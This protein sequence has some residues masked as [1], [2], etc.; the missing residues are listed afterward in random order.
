MCRKAAPHSPSCTFYYEY[1]K[2]NVRLFLLIA[3]LLTF[4]MFAQPP[5]EK[6]DFLIVEDPSYFLIYN[7]YQQRMTFRESARLLPYQPLQIL[8]EDDFLSDG[9]TPCMKVKSGSEIYFVIKDREGNLVTESEPNYQQVFKN[10]TVLED[11]AEVINGRVIF[12]AK[13]PTYKSTLRSKKYF[14]EKG[15]QLLRLFSKDGFVYVQNL[16]PETDFG[17]SNLTAN[18]QNSWWRIKKR[19]SPLNTSIPPEISR[20]IEEKIREVNYIVE[21]LF[22]YF[23][24]QSTQQKTAPRWEIEFTDTQITCSINDPA[25]RENFPESTRYLLNS[26]ENILLG[27]PYAVFYHQGEIE[28]LRK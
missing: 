23:N 20:K 8:E 27:T 17:W 26:L 19:T 18:K 5:A 10:C 28:V 22:S 6:A 9:Y 14:L 24:Q 11:T 1:E 16:G 13:I 7:K 2:M 4:A 12:I 25:F 21:Q 3:I 15:T